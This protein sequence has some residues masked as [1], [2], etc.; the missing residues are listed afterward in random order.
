MSPDAIDTLQLV[1]MPTFNASREWVNS[2]SSNTTIIVTMMEVF[3]ERVLL[4]NENSR[5][6]P[7]GRTI[8]TAVYLCVLSI[9][10]SVPVFYYCRL[11]CEERQA[12]RLQDLELAGITQA[13]AQS[14]NQHRQESR[15]ARRKF[16]E[17]R[18][19]RIHQLF[20]PVK[21]VRPRYIFT[22]VYAHSWLC[23]YPFGEDRLLLFEGGGGC[24][25]CRL[26]DKLKSTCFLRL[27]VASI[28]YPYC[29]WIAVLFCR[30]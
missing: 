21:M 29:V 8:W 1:V 28:W 15:A 9:C 13:L 5:D 16:R 2:S 20:G 6:V 27:S 3:L 22:Y 19:A 26:G 7:R 18:R 12:R 4:Q 24:P 23:A 17:E 30:P 10:F 14:H 25:V 11:H